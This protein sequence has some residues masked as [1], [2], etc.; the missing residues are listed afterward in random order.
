MEERTSVAYDLKGV[1]PWVQ[2]LHPY[3]YTRSD[4]IRT[5][6]NLAHTSH[7]HGHQVLSLQ[8]GLRV[9]SPHYLPSVRSLV[10]TEPRGSED[11]SGILTSDV[12]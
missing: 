10:R 12:L 11:S 8:G 3:I 9:P 7:E 4:R 2:G 6:R 5:W 1:V